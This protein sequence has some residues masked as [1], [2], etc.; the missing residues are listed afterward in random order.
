M[1]LESIVMMLAPPS[2]VLVDVAVAV[3]AGGCELPPS[4]FLPIALRQ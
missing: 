2:E 1:C 3:S 4:M